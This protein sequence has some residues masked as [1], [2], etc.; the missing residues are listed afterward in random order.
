MAG[1]W[2]TWTVVLGPVALLA[3]GLLPTAWAN[4]HPRAMAQVAGA[5]SGLALATALVAL[6]GWGVAGTQV[7]GVAVLMIYLDALS[8]TM[9]LLVSFIGA[10]VVRFSANYLGGDPQHGR[11]MKW[12]CLT[13]AAVLALI[14]SGNLVLFALAWVATSL[15]LHKLLVFYADRPA[16]QLAARKKFLVSRL[17]DACLIGAM[18]LIWVAF[19]T[20]DLAAIFAA[21][22]GMRAGGTEPAH[23]QGIAVLLV[24]GALLKSAQ[25][26]F[27]GWLLEVMET[28][29]PV[30]ALLHAG[31]INAGGF[32]VVRMSG[33]VALSATAL[34]ILVLAG[35]TTALFGSIVM[36][37]QTSIKVALAYSTVGQMGFMMLECGLGAFSAA[38]LHIVAHAFYKA[39]AF[40]SSGSAVEA[41]QARTDDI[42]EGRRPIGRLMLAL[43]AA[44]V[45]TLATGWVFGVLHKPGMLVLGAV[46]TMGVAHLLWAGTATR[47]TGYVVLRG[48]GLA[49]AVCIAYF[50][51]Q[52]GFE[53]LLVG[54]VP[55]A[56]TVAHDAFGTILAAAVILLFGAAIVVQALLPR[57]A[58]SRRWRAIYVHLL[59]GLYVN[60]MANRLVEHIWATGPSGVARGARP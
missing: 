49:L 60:S 20:L 15:C 42:G 51:L 38:V 12:L 6:V 17:G 19:G 59:N 1:A 16:A 3:T 46:L 9:L 22:E 56:A 30:S 33:I 55:P 58:G 57:L 4:R 29:T 37:T 43:G 41:A 34:D 28:P 53:R 36:L 45:M 14:V 13:L 8:A 18:A 54:A 25:F 24:A 7:R 50:A 5:A 39:H 32:L 48:A 44:V 35:A 23:L 2:M 27:H 52:L 47:L 26:P 11:F 21:V 10:V 40:L 31:I